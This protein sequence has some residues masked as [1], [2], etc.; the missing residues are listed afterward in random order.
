ML[1]GVLIRSGKIG[2]GSD[3]SSI[4]FVSFDFAECQP[5]GKRRIGITPG[6][7][8]RG[9]R[10]ADA[11]VGLPFALRNPFILTSEPSILTLDDPRQRDHRIG[12]GIDRLAASLNQS[13][14][15]CHLAQSGAIDQFGCPFTWPLACKYFDHQRII[16]TPT[17]NQS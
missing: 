12:T 15:L 10:L 4:L 1:Q 17:F 16:R 7:V 2:R 5:E 11:G 9:D 6:A 8:D 3:F 13:L 14:S